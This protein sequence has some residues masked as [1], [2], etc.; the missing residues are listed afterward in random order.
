MTDIARNTDPQT[1]H[2]GADEL[3]RS[4][5]RRTQKEY[6][7]NVLRDSPN[8]MTWGEMKFITGIEYP[9]KRLSDLKN[10]GLIEQRGKRRF[11]GNDQGEWGVIPQQ[12]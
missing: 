6:I 1:S 3:N 8:G 7:L 10:D 12:K 5:R 11:N 4:G 2:T 9:W